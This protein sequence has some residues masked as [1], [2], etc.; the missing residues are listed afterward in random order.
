MN[1]HI[2]LRILI[3]LLLPIDRKLQLN[4]VSEPNIL[5]CGIDVEIF[6]ARLST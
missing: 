4:S 3:H 2:S 6:L 5:S 1:F